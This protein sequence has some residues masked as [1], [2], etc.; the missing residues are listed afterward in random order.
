MECKEGKEEQRPLA[1]YGEVRLRQASI[2]NGDFE[3][4]AVLLK[5]K[6][7]GILSNINLCNLIH[8]GGTVGNNREKL[9]RNSGLEQM[10]TC[11]CV[12]TP[13]AWGRRL[14]WKLA[15]ESQTSGVSIFKYNNQGRTEARVQKTGGD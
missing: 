15:I 8:F 14:V 9:Q 12:C 7:Q 10:C 2:V 4:G 3:F 6:F 13:E 5:L 1:D 11:V